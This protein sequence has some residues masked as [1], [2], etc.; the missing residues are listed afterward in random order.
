MYDGVGAR[1]ARA[2]PPPAAPRGAPGARPRGGGNPTPVAAGSPRAR[3]T[4]AT[5][6]AR[7]RSDDSRAR[8]ISKPSKRVESNRIER[9]NDGC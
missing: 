2:P 4:E 5:R 7:D 6:R 8:S 9:Y 1:R 3:A